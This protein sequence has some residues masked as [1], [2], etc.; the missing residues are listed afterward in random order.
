MRAAEYRAVADQMKKLTARA[1]FR[2]LAATYQAMARR[3]EARAEKKTPRTS[4]S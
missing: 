1:S 2:R 3:L 4:A